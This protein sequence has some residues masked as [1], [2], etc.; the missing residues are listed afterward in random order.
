MVLFLG[1]VAC[2]F[3]ISLPSM[4]IELFLFYSGISGLQVI[5]FLWLLAREITTASGGV[6]STYTAR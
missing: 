5:L 3:L 2:S 4:E 6:S 1:V